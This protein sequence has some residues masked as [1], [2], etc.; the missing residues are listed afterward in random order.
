[1][2]NARRPGQLYL[3]KLKYAAPV[4]NLDE[5]RKDYCGSSSIYSEIAI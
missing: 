3:A 5:M 2:R 4:S 1:M